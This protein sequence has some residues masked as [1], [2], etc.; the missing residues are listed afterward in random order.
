MLIGQAGDQLA[1]ADRTHLL[2]GVCENGECVVVAPAGVLQ[3]LQRGQNHRQAALVV[4]DP[5]TVQA[6]ALDLVGLAGKDAGLV[7]RVHV[8]LQH[9]LALARAFEDA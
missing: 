3:D 8:G 1:R 7:D 4:S 9:D 6:I 5:G 2:I